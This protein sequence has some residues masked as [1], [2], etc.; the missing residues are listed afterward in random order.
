MKKGFFRL[1][2]FAIFA[3]MLQSSLVLGAETN[4]SATEGNS[5]TVL[6]AFDQQQTQHEN[7]QSTIS[8]HQKQV[9]MFVMGVPL[10]IL[11]L[12]TAAIGIAM[13]IF[14]K[15]WFLAH[16]ILASLTISLALAHVVVG[17]V[18]FY[19]F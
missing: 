7:N 4:A 1:L 14:G 2:T 3:L 5:I 6:Q 16:M 12:L 9:V 17:L 18:W 10:L 11:I 15:P 8:A 19:P 13:G